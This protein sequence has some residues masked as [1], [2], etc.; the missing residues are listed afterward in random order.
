M[1]S[2]NSLHNAFLHEDMYAA[3]ESRALTQRS[4]ETPESSRM[5][6]L[7]TTGLEQFDS[8][9]A[10]HLQ[11]E[12]ASFLFAARR[13]SARGYAHGMLLRKAEQQV[14]AASRAGGADKEHDHDSLQKFQH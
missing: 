5:F 2:E 13:D 14:F 6:D 9:M 3:G 4:A 1:N 11:E 7:L 12:F 10:R 8:Y